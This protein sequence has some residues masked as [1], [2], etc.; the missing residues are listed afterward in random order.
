MSSKASKK[1]IML[2]L[3][4]VASVDWT[5]EFG[6]KLKLM[7]GKVSRRALAQKVIDQY[8]YKVSQQYIQLLEHPEG[9]EKAP[10]TVS[11]KLLRYLT[12]ALDTDVYELFDSPQIFY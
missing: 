3:D 2:E 5:P 6:Q 10:A 12:E 8:D 7:R 1:F 4:V 9:N 11:F